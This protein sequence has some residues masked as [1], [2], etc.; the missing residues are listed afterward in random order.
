MGIR[1]DW[2]PFRAR[3]ALQ[4]TAAEVR[5]RAA[6]HMAERARMYAPVDTGFLKSEIVVV[7]PSGSRSSHVLARADYSQFVEFGHLAGGVTWVAPNP[8]MRRALADTARAFPE[9]AK[10]VKVLRPGSDGGG[11]NLGATFTTD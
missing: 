8:F 4:E 1:F 10:G 2:N 9:I 6:E 11:D 7:S 5:R 3:K